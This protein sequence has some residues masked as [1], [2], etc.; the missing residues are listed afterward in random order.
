MA[1]TVAMVATVNTA[2][3]SDVTVGSVMEQRENVMVM[4]VTEE[5]VVMVD[6]VAEVGVTN[7]TEVSGI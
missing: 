5:M 4:V 6:Q 7:G 2:V 3:A 1:V